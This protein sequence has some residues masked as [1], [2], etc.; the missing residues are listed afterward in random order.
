[1]LFD[2][3]KFLFSSIKVTF[4]FSLTLV[5]CSE[6]GMLSAKFSTCLNS[7]ADDVEDP[8]MVNNYLTGLF[9][10]VHSTICQLVIEI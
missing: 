3:R 10:E 6:I 2:A 8:H 7:S 1:M 9:L 4:I 5:F